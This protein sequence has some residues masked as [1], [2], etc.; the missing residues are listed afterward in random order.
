MYEN[1]N[2]NINIQASNKI[3]NC[4]IPTYNNKGKIEFFNN[5]INHINRN[6]NKNMDIIDNLIKKSISI[7]INYKYDYNPKN[8]NN[9]P[10]KRRNSFNYSNN[11]EKYL[12]LKLKIKNIADNKNSVTPTKEIILK[13]DD[14]LTIK[15]KFK[16]TILMNRNKLYNNQTKLSESKDKIKSIESKNNIEE[17]EK[18]ARKKNKKNKKNK[19]N[20]FSSKKLKTN[21]NK[22]DNTQINLNT[23]SLDEEKENNSFKDKDNDIDIKNQ[24][25]KKKR[26]SISTNEKLNKNNN[27]KNNKNTSNNEEENKNENS[28]SVS[29]IS[30]IDEQEEIY[31]DIEIKKEIDLLSNILSNKDI[32]NLFN[33]IFELKKMLRIKNKTEEIKNDISM[34]KIEIKNIIYSFFEQLLYKLTIKEIKEDKQ[35]L[36]IKYLK[37]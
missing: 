1:I 36:E 26:E 17:I 10:I 30:S 33:S 21:K 11:E 25:N 35:H 14:I 32:N 5:K 31:E 29:S 8:I 37:N 13:N 24:I 9:T 4:K 3:E 22:I 2:S 20:N 12:I 16:N 7:D 34:L 27:N 15:P 28:E 6:N 19:M 18:K 23:S